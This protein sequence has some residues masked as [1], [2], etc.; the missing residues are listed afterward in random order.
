MTA[1]WTRLALVVMAGLLG[2]PCPAQAQTPSV[3]LHTPRAFGYFAGDIVRLEVVLTTGP[4][5]RLSTASLPHPRAIH[6]WLDLHA[7]STEEEAADSGR[8]YRIRLDYQLLD[9]PLE[10][11]ERTIPPVTLKVE[12]PSGL[13][14]A[15]VP[16]WTLLMAPLR[17]ALPAPAAMMPDATP[18]PIHTARHLWLMLAAMVGALL[19]LA[20]LAYHNAWPPFLRPAARPFTAAWRAISARS[21]VRGETVYR[22]SLL[23]LHRAFDAAAGRRIFAADIDPFLESRPE[24]RAARHDIASFFDASRRAF[25]A[26]DPAGAEAQHPGEAVAALSRRLSRLERQGA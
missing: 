2:P 16:A 7:V 26:S 3:E 9:A 8:R 15:S 11:A 24:F 14:D 4:E 6:H 13:S 12:G 17:G 21:G 18:H 10:A 23:T 25:F 22:D 20:M 5:S 19:A 1:R